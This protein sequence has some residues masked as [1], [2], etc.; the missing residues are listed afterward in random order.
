MTSPPA[1]DPEVGDDPD[2]RRLVSELP[3]ALASMRGD[4]HRFVV[5]NRAYRDMF[6]RHGLI[7]RTMYEAFPEIAGQGGFEIMER[8]QRTGVPSQHRAVRFFIAP[9]EG[10]PPVEHF[11]DILVFPSED[12]VHW[13]TFDV[14]ERE[15]A[16][17]R[18][19][20]LAAEAE[21][22][23]ADA[24]GMVTTLQEALL[25][26]ELPVLATL[27]LSAHYLPADR[28]EGAGGDWFDAVVRPSGR[29][30]L[31]VG[32]VVGHGI[33]ASAVMGQLRAV[34]R[35]H[36]L[37]PGSLGSVLAAVDLYARA[38][39][40]AYAATVCLAEV[41]TLTGAVTYCTAGHPPPL[42][43]SPARSARFLEPTGG[44]PLATGDR[45]PVRD[46]HLEPEEMLLL[47]SDG[48]VERPGRDLAESTVEIVTT[49]TDVAQGRGF[50]R[51]TGSRPGDV[52]GRHSLEILTRSTGHTDDITVLVAHR[53]EP[54]PPLGLDLE[55]TP[56]NQVRLRETV[57]DWLARLN[58]SGSA[59]VVVQHAAGELFANAVRHAYPEDAGER[60]VRVDAS[61]GP[62]GLLCLEVR[63]EGAWRT[64]APDEPGRGL[65]MVRRLVDELKI[66]PGGTGTAVVARTVL[67][68]DAQLRGPLG[69]S[70][71]SA[72]DV[73]FE[74]QRSGPVLQ[75]SGP[76]DLLEAQ[77]L[78]DELVL[79]TRGGTEIVAVDLA[80]VTHL[81]SAAV[82]VLH[83]LNA[84]EAIRLHAPR[85]TVAQQVLDLVGLPYVADQVS[86]QG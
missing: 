81:G 84:D 80:G 53:T 26:A 76:V 35:S 11:L 74:L 47:Y 8:V 15:V 78:H 82:R 58:V 40:G 27:D 29:V 63:D 14:T 42:V 79:S 61:L 17:R 52:V 86:P 50:P 13:I 83:A 75:V 69:S 46:A 16:Q 19:E 66:D 49:V 48:L 32:D 70:Q 36:L 7:G 6:G 60:P 9:D 1:H 24:R 37:G 56:E 77:R 22:R 44:L 43:A 30:A 72:R 12:G 57:G 3:V 20:R 38:T 5:T 21:Q 33:A 85:G 71:P 51:E 4:E 25:P 28:D 64:P 31:V 59:H 54:V 67:T 2:I 18:A 62:E 41:D 23:Y 73:A 68:R 34:L 45:F 39:P 65:A 55:A 10:S